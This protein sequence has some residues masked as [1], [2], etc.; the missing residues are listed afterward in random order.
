MM[1]ADLLE[2]QK[3]ESF[4]NAVHA[5][6][7]FAALMV[8]GVHLCDGFNTHFFPNYEPLNEAMPYIKRFGTFGV[9]LFFVISGYVI[10]NSLQRHPLRDF[11]AR[12]MVRIY[13][14]FCFFTVCFFTLNWILRLHPESLSV[15][16]L[17]L[18]LGFLN[19][20]F[21]TEALS[22]N[23]WSLTFEAN[24]YLL[25]GLGCFLLRRHTALPLMLLGAAS[26]AFLVCFPIA[27]YFLIGCLLYAGRHLQPTSLPRS[28]EFA[29]LA[30]WC[31]LAATVD[32]EAISVANIAL[33]GASVLFFFV[34]TTPN[35][36]LA[37][38]A[39]WQ[40][41]FFI[42]TISYSFYLT[43]PY[44]Y[45][46]LRVLFQKLSI[47]TWNIGL[48]AAVYFPCISAAAVVASYFIYRLL[49]V[50]PYRAAF[51][52]SVFRR[53]ACRRAGTVG[54]PAPTVS[55]G[56]WPLTPAPTGS[57]GVQSSQSRQ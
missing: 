18:N 19:I 21:G 14:V 57:T 2:R 27:A 37:Q 3:P 11:L 8:F 43:H 41:V 17:F 10:M 1:S 52:E 6:R 24:F 48:A 40:S 32:H 39:A 31:V 53:P 54:T 9:E 49:E 35:G 26:I 45:F 22:P 15:R 16:T 28:A 50:A 4:N 25:T 36:T 44:A 7:A 33:L 30:L 56:G 23:A 47:D 55:N 34:I 51:G 38:I 5:L 20:Y 13:P 42:G 29:I 46:L 12:R